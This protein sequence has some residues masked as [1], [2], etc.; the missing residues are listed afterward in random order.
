MIV[1][2][3][4]IQI[5]RTKPHGVTRWHAEIRE[6]IPDTPMRT[7]PKLW[8]SQDPDLATISQRATY[9]LIKILTQSHEEARELS[10]KDMVGDIREKEAARAKL[11]QEMRD[12]PEAE[13]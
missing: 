5:Y 2:D 13:E 9:S 4:V 10:V 8:A 11:A 7:W 1:R 12:Q 3:P 6:R